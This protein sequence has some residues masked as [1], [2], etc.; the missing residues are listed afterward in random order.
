MNLCAQIIP[1]DLSERCSLSPP[2]S[3]T[4]S[5]RGKLLS[6]H[7]GG[8]QVEQQKR[9]AAHILAHVALG[10]GVEGGKLHITRVLRPHLVKHFL[11]GVESA[12][13][14]VHV[15]LVYL[16][17]NR[18]VVMSPSGRPEGRYVGTELAREGKVTK[19]SLGQTSQ[20]HFQY[21]SYT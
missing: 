14:R 2:D 5:K 17:G 19:S 1:L 10:G 3:Y 21:Y 4:S 7:V 16:Q 12:V 9:I 6:N 15:V 11:K 13:R 18:T 8:P 20:S